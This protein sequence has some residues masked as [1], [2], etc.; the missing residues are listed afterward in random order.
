MVVLLAVV[1]TKSNKGGGKERVAFAFVRK[2]KTE[3]KMFLAYVYVSVCCKV[4][5]FL[6][7][8]SLDGWRDDSYRHVNGL[9]QVNSLVFN[10][11][12]YNVCVF[13]LGLGCCKS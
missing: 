5:W 11:Q 4:C 2:R 12:N 7:S 9:L 6:Y 3:I 13:N 1:A 8:E 10:F